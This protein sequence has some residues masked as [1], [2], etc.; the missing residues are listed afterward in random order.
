VPLG[1]IQRGQRAWIGYQVLHP[2]SAPDRIQAHLTLVPI[3]GTQ[4]PER[5]GQAV[6]VENRTNRQRLVVG[7]RLAEVAQQPCPAV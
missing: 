7:L 1:H 2:S 3:D 5:V 4:A 6:A